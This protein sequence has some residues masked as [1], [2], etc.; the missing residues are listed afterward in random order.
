[1]APLI[2]EAAYANCPTRYPQVGGEGKESTATTALLL[3]PMANPYHS[4][5]DILSDRATERHGGQ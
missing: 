5:R 1:M 3:G 4:T 2:F